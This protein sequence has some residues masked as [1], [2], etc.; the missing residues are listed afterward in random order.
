MACSSLPGT[1]T[2]NPLAVRTFLEC[3]WLPSRVALAFPGV[4]SQLWLGRW[5]LLVAPL[6]HAALQGLASADPGQ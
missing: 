6:L 4:S 3:F 1:G 5:W 2:W